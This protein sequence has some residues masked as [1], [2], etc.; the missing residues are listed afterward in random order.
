MEGRLVSGNRPT[1]RWGWAWL[2][3][4]HPRSPTD[5]RAAVDTRPLGLSVARQGA[6]LDRPRSSFYCDWPRA[7]T[8]IWRGCECSTSLTRRA[9]ACAACLWSIRGFL[10]K[11][12]RSDLARDGRRYL[13]GIPSR[14]PRA[15]LRLPGRCRRAEI[16]NRTTQTLP[17]ARHPPEPRRTLVAHASVEL[18]ECLVLTNPRSGLLRT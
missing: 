13:A 12:A 18:S 3:K 14:L 7:A 1:G 4:T 2:K 11:V 8:R 9:H 6:L 15:T 10:Q 5:R 16:A 17:R